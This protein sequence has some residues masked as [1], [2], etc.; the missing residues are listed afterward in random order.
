VDG[1]LVEGEGVGVRVHVDRAGP[2]IVDG[3]AVHD[4][5]DDFSDELQHDNNPPWAD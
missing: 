5:R 3:H 4:R 2:L 1:M